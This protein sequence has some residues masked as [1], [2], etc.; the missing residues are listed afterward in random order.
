MT[1]LY[2]DIADL[3][4]Q[5]GRVRD[6]NVSQVSKATFYFEQGRACAT[7]KFPPHAHVDG[8]FTGSHPYLKATPSLKS[9]LVKS[10]CYL[11]NGSAISQHDTPFSIAKSRE[12][13]S[14]SM[15]GSLIANVFSRAR[16]C[17]S[18]LVF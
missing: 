3:I 6:V 5:F 12:Y 16:S 4:E 7:L 8:N 11:F 18:F 2:F 14:C 1:G 13:A 15:M 17:F 9:P 10:K